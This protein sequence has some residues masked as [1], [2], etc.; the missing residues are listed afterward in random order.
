MYS[1]LHTYFCPT[2]YFIRVNLTII[3][4]TDYEETIW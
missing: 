2:L 1:Q 4:V 3:L